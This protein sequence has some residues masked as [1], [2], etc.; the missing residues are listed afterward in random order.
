MILKFL[1]KLGSM[2]KKTSL[3][4]LTILTLFAIISVS[5]L[6]TGLIFYTRTDSNMVP[7]FSLHMI[8]VGATTAF[9]ELLII[10]LTTISSNFLDKI[11]SKIEN[12]VKKEKK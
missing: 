6:V 10:A 7:S 2:S 3:I 9:I 5:L 8:I 4:F 12:K 1:S 11:N